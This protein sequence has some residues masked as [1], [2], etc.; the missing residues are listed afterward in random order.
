M[1][2]LTQQTLKRME[3]RLN[4]VIRLEHSIRQLNNFMLTTAEHLEIH[5][6]SYFI[7]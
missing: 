2:E 1:A 6:R 5:V 4:D 7:N 3:I